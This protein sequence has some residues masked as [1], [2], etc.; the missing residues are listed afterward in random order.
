MEKETDPLKEIPD[1]LKGFAK[2]DTR[3]AWVI[4]MERI[5]KQLGKI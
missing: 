2:Q 5:N 3:P 1:F 4:D